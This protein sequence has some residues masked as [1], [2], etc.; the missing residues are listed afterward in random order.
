MCRRVTQPRRI[1]QV[2]AA[3]TLAACAPCAVLFTDIDIIHLD[4]LG[5]VA[6][7][8]LADTHGTRQAVTRSTPPR[9]RVAGQQAG[10]VR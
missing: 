9:T 2:H 8:Q 10:A 7:R 6:C 4:T 3:A 1:H 5:R